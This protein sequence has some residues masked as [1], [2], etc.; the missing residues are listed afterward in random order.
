MAMEFQ[1]NV[2]WV[3]TVRIAVV[4]CICFRVPCC[5]HLQGQV[6]LEAARSSKT[7]LSYCNTTQHHDPEDVS[8]KNQGKIILFYAV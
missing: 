7:L 3:V 8:L 6:K 5:F 1:V 2:F 4:G